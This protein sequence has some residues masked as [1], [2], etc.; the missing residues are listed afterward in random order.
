MAGLRLL[1]AQRPAVT[2]PGRSERRQA[3][4]PVYDQLFRAYPLHQDY[5]GGFTAFL[6]LMESESPDPGHLIK[7]ATSYTSNVDP[8]DMKYVPLIKNWLKGRRYE[9]EDLFTDQRVASREWFIRAYADG[10]AA[11]VEKRFGF[12]FPDPP[13]PAGCS[14]VL[15]WHKDARK[16]WIG[17]VARHVLH[18]EPLPE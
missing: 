18:G 17:A 12:I 16:T 8:K 14:D 6:D 11:S 2:N 3:L 13:V 9:D 7:K 1:L 15:S 5:G 4:Q 10:D